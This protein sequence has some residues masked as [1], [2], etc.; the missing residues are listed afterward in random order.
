[1]A[2][3]GHV[4]ETPQYSRDDRLRAKTPAAS[5]DFSP[6]NPGCEENAG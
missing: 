6:K 4:T 5:P 1:L 3:L 2:A